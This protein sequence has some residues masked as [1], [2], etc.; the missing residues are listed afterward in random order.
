[1]VPLSGLKLVFSFILL[2]LYFFLFGLPS[3]T[4]FQ[5]KQ[6]LVLETTN[7][8]DGNADP[9]ITGWRKNISSMEGEKVFQTMCNQSTNAKEAYDCINAGTYNLSEM[10]VKAIDKN[11]DIVDKSAWQEEITRYNA[12]RCQTLQ[13]SVGLHF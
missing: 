7:D 12:G 9:A 2:Y 5:A 3:L 10:I 8:Q 4:K 13:S 6:T 1:M 11:K